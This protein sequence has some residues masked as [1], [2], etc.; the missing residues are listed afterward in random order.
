MALDPAW[1][2]FVAEPR[3]AALLVDFDGSLAPIVDD[4][5]ARACPLPAARRRAARARRPGSARVAV[6]SGRPVEF[7]ATRIVPDRRRRSSA[8]TGWSAGSTARSSTDPRVEPSSSR[9]RG[10]RRGGRAPLAPALLVERK[11]TVAVTLHWRTAPDA[12]PTP[13]RSAAL[14]RGRTGS[15]RAPGRMACELR[16][17]VPVDKGTAVAELLAERAR[18]GG[19]RRR[20][21][22]A[23]SPRSPRSTAGAARRAGHAAVRIA[24]ALGGGA[25]RAARAR[26]T[27]SSTGPPGLAAL[28][29]ELAD[30]V[31]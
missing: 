2:P 15:T 5:D 18:R 12:A 22:R 31:S 24:V 6:V 7:L 11:G 9:G 23:T 27:C 25:A 21:P 13:A 3:R 29:D 8:S 30:A 26:P 1:S 14:G 4:P 10:G 17:P 19:V 20:R 28:L 16:P